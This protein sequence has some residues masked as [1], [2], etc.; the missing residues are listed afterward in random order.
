VIIDL[1]IVVAGEVNAPLGM[2][3]RVLFVAIY[4]HSDRFDIFDVGNE[5]P[6]TKFLL[7]SITQKAY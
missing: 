1:F 4:R 5:V 6:F 2:D 7:L 3:H